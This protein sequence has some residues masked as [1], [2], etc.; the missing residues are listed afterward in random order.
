MDMLNL[1]HTLQQ[2]R[3]PLEQDR[4][5]ALDRKLKNHE[6]KK[7]L[8]KTA[9]QFEGIF[10]K[11]LMDAMDKTVDRSGFMSGGS[12]EEMFRSMLFD[13]VS[14]LAATRPGGTGFGIAEAIYRQLE[15]LV[16]EDN[17]SNTKGGAS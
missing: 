5:M 2:T 6:N 11:Q 8:M 16:R 1:N 9:Q 17:G 10:L 14:E 12:G 13:K 7:E 15:P 4:V 3:L